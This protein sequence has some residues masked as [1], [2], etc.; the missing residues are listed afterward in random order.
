MEHQ[1]DTIIICRSYD[2]STP[3]RGRYKSP[4]MLCITVHIF[5]RGGCRILDP[6]LVFVMDVKSFSAT[7]SETTQS[8]ALL[9]IQGYVRHSYWHTCLLNVNF[10]MGHI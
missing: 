6:Q 1:G 9:P 5:Y 3:S 2:P 10:E 4:V 7:S 8:F